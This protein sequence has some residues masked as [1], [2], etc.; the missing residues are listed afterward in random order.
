MT[1]LPKR[2]LMTIGL[3][4]LPLQS[5]AQEGGVLTPPHPPRPYKSVSEPVNSGGKVL[6][7]DPAKGPAVVIESSEKDY[8]PGDFDPENPKMIERKPGQDAAPVK[9]ENSEPG[10]KA[11]QPVAVE[12]EK[13]AY[14][15]T[16]AAE[17]PVE[18]KSIREKARPPT[19]SEDKIKVPEV[20]VNDGAPGSYAPK[21]TV[22]VPLAD[23]AEEAPNIADEPK[24]ASPVYVPADAAKLEQEEPAQETSKVEDKKAEVA[25]ET[26]PTYAPAGT[27][28]FSEEDEKAAPS[29][30][31]ATPKMP[32]LKTS[33]G[34][35]VTGAQK[36]AAPVSG[37]HA[38]QPVA[39]QA[40]RP[41]APRY[42][43]Q[44][45]YWQPYQPY[46]PWP[47]WGYAPRQPQ[48]QPQPG[49]LQQPQWQ[50]QPQW[51]G[52]GYRYPVPPNWYPYQNQ[53]IP[54]P[55]YQP[56]VQPQARPQYQPDFQPGANS[57]QQPK[58]GNGG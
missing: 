12:V 18:V 35:Q 41:S 43:P 33:E 53:W 15:P 14:A 40:V 32:E 20:P 34:S 25:K 4:C 48:W 52:A 29:E 37:T 50:R 5:W 39:R 23:K 17:L 21:E 13:P 42:Y 10:A 45:R 1:F 54:R 46:Q 11:S 3:A 19:D 28:E 24:K 47:Q 58:Q 8:P 55:Q 31:A 27:A 36:S 38:Q 44:R 2:T 26:P 49:W 22:E 16:S 7:Q 30:N 57:F 56:Q 6:G 9:V 51:P